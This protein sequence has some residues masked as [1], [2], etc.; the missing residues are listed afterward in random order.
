MER[1]GQLSSIISDDEIELLIRTLI[2]SGTPEEKQEVEKA[3]GMF[4]HLCETR[5]MLS[6]EDEGE[7]DE[8]EKR[9]KEVEGM[10]ARLNG[11][12]EAFHRNE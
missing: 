3:M 10:Y 4:E 2:K 5:E 11:I 1:F 7:R 12:R 6:R 9:V 8:V